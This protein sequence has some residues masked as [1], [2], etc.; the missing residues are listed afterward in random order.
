[1]VKDCATYPKEARRA[2]QVVVLMVDSGKEEPW[3]P[4]FHISLTRRPLRKSITIASTFKFV[5][6][7]SNAKVIN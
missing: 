2:S 3:A 6:S 5:T 4:T 7:Y 1:M